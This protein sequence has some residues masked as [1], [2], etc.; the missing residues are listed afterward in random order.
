MKTRKRTETGR[1]FGNEL[2]LVVSVTERC[3]LDVKVTIDAPVLMLKYQ[4]TINRV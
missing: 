4:E 3:V 2:K 1:Q